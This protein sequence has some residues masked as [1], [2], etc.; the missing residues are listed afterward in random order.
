[1]KTLFAGLAALTATFSV[2]TA[3]DVT[4]IHAGTLLAVPGE[5]PLTEQTI[6]IRNDRIESVLPGYIAGAAI[7]REGQ[8][9]ETRG[10]STD[11]LDWDGHWSVGDG[12][13]DSQAEGRASGDVG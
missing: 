11:S 6:V 5:V 3:E 9:P 8:V 1:M 2:A 12:R 4:I 13:E 7:E 10:A